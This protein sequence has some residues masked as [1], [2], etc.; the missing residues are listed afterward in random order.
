[1]K[2]NLIKM[3][4]LPLAIFQIAV[5]L[6]MLLG[7]SGCETD[8]PVREDVPE[9]ITKATLT[10]TPSSGGNDIVVMQPILTVKV[11][12]IFRLMGRSILR[13]IKA[14]PFA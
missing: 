9:L 3:H 13:R 10:F 14:I 11:C 12:R 4:I 1:M 6:T 8:D 7:L 2:K 5:A